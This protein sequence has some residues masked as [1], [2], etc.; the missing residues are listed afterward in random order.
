MLCEGYVNSFVDFFYLTHRINEE[1]A[2][3]TTTKQQT[4]YTIPERYYT[5]LK[6]Q[7]TTA[8]SGHR[9]GD[10]N[11]VLEAYEQ[12]ATYFQEN[13]DYKTAI[14]FHEKCL[15]LSEAVGNLAQQGIACNNL[16]VAY[17][18]MEDLDGAIRFHERHLKIAHEIPDH[19][20]AMFASKRLADAYL[21]QATRLRKADNHRD[22]LQFHE[23]CLKAAL[24]CGDTQHEAKAA[25]AIG[26]TCSEVGSWDEARQ[27]Q[28]RCLALSRHVQDAEGECGAHLALAAIYKEQED[29]KNAT[30]HYEQCYTVAVRNNMLK[31]QAEVCSHLGVIANIINQ[32]DKS[33]AYFEKAYEIA[34]ELKDRKL[35]DSARIHLGMARGNLGIHAYVDVLTH[36]KK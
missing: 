18:A 32:H 22:A 21:R 1:A 10:T 4:Q 11:K 5:E 36:P 28:E 19:D 24:D 29:L 2:D 7:L 30:I 25:H 16:A 33:I 23:K 3:L 9:H 35:I 31:I 20:R 27:W 34:K 6:R 15:D 17:D 14:Y 12:L 26:L 13:K 8:E